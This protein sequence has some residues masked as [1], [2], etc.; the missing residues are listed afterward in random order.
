MKLRNAFNLIFVSAFFF[1]ILLF[2]VRVLASF[3][4][5]AVPNPQPQTGDPQNRWKVTFNVASTDPAY[6]MHILVTSLAPIG[7]TYQT[8]Q[9]TDDFPP[10][11]LNLTHGYAFS[12]LPAGY[13]YQISVASMV[14]G[15][16][17]TIANLCTF[18]TAGAG[19]TASV[20]SCQTSASS[21]GQGSSTGNTTG[22]TGT[23]TTTGSSGTS[24]GG[25][26]TAQG[27]GATQTP[28][29]SAPS[30]NAAISSGGV[31]SALT[32]DTEKVGDGTCGDGRDNGDDGKVDWDGV[33]DAAGQPRFP[34][35]PSCLT[36][37]M[38]ETG[39][40]A[41]GSETPLIPC[42]NKCDLPA[43][44]TLLNNALSFFFT[45]FL[46][47]ISICIFVYAGY[48]YIMAQGNAGK[49]ANIKKMIGNLI[50]GIVIIL[51]A[52]LLVNTALRVVGYNQ[53]LLFFQ[54]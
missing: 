15:Q 46:A 36:K 37:D 53:S 27:G 6:D 29:S 41:T 10:D 30:S 4:I 43:F 33:R 7:N 50:L 31:S 35:D 26:S 24:S 49:R 52:W 14:S 38:T 3:Y 32:Y 44:F 39:D 48:Q 5:S 2:P 42:V 19:G 17:Q 34:P 20:G 45:V 22:N 9:A 16:L 11:D 28:A 47:P 12:L 25:T 18:K 54:E 13:S 8:W 23:N 1:F 51:V 21:S 40:I